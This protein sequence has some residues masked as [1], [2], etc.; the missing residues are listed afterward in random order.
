MIADA[1]AECD[2]L[3]AVARAEAEQFLAAARTESGRVEA[4][5]QVRRERE[6][7]ALV[8]HTQRLRTE[9]D[10]LSGL[11]LQYQEDLRAWL[12]EQQ[13]LLEQRIPLLDVPYVAE[14]ASAD[15]LRPAA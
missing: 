5:L 11:A 12:S 6:V 1:G 4:E 14:P 2:E 3:R 13:R 15:M 8:I 9:I 10:R 7:G